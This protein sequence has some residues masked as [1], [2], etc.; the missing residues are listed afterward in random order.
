MAVQISCSLC[1]GAL[2]YQTVPALI[3]AGYGSRYAA[4][5]A[6]CVMGVA[7]AGVLLMGTLSDRFTGRKV[8]PLYVAALGTAPLLLLG[9]YGTSDWRVCLT[10]FVIVFGVSTGVT[11]CV[12]P[13]V[14]AEVLGL[15]CFGTL[16]GILSMAGMVAGAVAPV[17]IGWLVDRTG[18]FA[19]GFAT[20]ASICCVAAAA[21]LVISPA[22]GIGELP[23]A[24][25]SGAIRH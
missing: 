21:A 18:S 17:V 1:I 15:K 8:L 19:F 25:I 24:A 23:V 4:L 6:S 13:V 5:A 20:C 2:F 10:A 7:I 9:A 3:H 14:L 16:N 11:S 22:E 12:T